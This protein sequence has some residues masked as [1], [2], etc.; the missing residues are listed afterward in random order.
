MPQHLHSPSFSAVK[1]SQQ[2][3]DLRAGVDGSRA[4]TLCKSIPVRL[5]TPLVS[6][7]IT[8]ALVP[9]RL[10][11]LSFGVDLDTDTSEK[12]LAVTPMGDGLFA[13]ATMAKQYGPDRET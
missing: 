8:D 9:L 13:V 5:T 12:S 4:E 1:P 3:R 6:G 10:A 11:L 2:M 7:E